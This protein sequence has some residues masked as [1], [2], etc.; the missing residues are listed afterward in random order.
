MTSEDGQGRGDGEQVDVEEELR[1]SFCSAGSW[2]AKG[3]GA[4]TSAGR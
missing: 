2:M 4:R 3:K 1:R